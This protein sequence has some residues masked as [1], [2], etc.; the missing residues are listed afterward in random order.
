VNSLN[1]FTGEAVK[2][3]IFAQ[4]TGGA[5]PPGFTAPGFP[6]DIGSLPPNG[7]FFFTLTIDVA[8]TV[9]PGTYTLWIIGFPGTSVAHAARVTVNVVTTPP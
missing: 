2:L 7:S 5:L 8:P 6:Q 1:A 9:T 3:G 4:P